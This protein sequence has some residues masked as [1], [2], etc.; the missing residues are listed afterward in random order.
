MSDNESF[1]KQALILARRAYDLNEIPVGAIVVKSGKIIGKGY[2]Q[3]E[4]LQDATAHAEIIAIT[5][6]ANYLK[7][8]KLKDC[9]LFTTL[10]PC[11]MCSGAIFNSRIRN[12]FFGAY[13]KQFGGCSSLY[14]LCNDPRLS[15]RSGIKGGIMEIDCSW[16]LNEFFQKLRE[17]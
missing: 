14:N 11:I 2:N 5:S 13:D 15:H 8:W 4:Q 12:V 9:D 10:E 7:S 3:I 1:M 6:A 16:I 17:K